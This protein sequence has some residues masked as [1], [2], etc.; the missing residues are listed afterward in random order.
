MKVARDPAM[1]YRSLL[2][3]L[4]HQELGKERPVVLALLLSLVVDLGLIDERA[5][6]PKAVTPLNRPSESG[7]EGA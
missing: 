7:P 1:T 3:E 4:A 5:P 2:T 6:D